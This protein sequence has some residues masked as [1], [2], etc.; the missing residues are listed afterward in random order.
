MLVVS[1][2]LIIPVHVKVLM[3]LF[4]ILSTQ[5]GLFTKLVFANGDVKIKLYM[6]QELN[7]LPEYCQYRLAETRFRNEFSG[8]NGK[9]NWPP[10]FG[11]SLNSW[12]QK[13]GPTSWTHIH[14]YCFGV[15]AFNE[16]SLDA[17]NKNETYKNNKLQRALNEFEYMRGAEKVNFPL[18]Y[19]LYR[20][21]AYIYMRLGNTAKAKWALEQSLRYKK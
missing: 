10:Y 17:A 20:Y 21:E 4:V 16:Y 15:S 18:W 13:I 19:E 12:V 6:Q 2:L 8:P 7:N 5:N 3:I 11:E 1:K 9:I 14:H